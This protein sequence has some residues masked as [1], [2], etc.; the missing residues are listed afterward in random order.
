MDNSVAI[1]GIGDIELE[2]GKVKDGLS[3]LQIQALSAK[4]A[5]NDAGIKK[6]EVD[7]MF[8]SGMWHKAGYGTAPSALV[9]E[10][11]GIQPR[12]TDSTN[13]GGASF[14]AHIGHAAAAIKD[15]KCE[16]ALIVY[17]STQRSDKSR[18]N[19]IPPILTAQYESPFGLPF[20]I[21]SYGMAAN[22][23]M[24]QYGVKQEDLAEVAVSARKWGQLNP[25]ATKRENLS[26]KDVLDSPI[27]SH[28]LHKLDCCLVT[29]GA[30]AIVLVSSEKAKECR[31]KPIWVLGHGE[32][33][34]HWS[35]QPMPDLTVSSAKESAR[36]AFEMSGISRKEID[37]VQVYDSFTI[38]VLI[39]L[40]SLG[41]CKPGEAPDFIKTKGI[42][43]DGNFPI[44]TSGGGLAHCHPGMYGIFLL[45]EAVRQLREEADGRQ[46]QNAKTALVNGTGGVLSSTSVC[47]LGRD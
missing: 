8:V 4:R 9:S 33:H 7:G 1:A 41:F 21:G 47:I 36:D 12:Y 46:V 37:V 14:E 25:S 40:E 11:L 34:S 22:R 24:H 18:N 31:K 10:Y 3:V 44:N 23:Y 29:D 26:V 15:G 30:G 39:T 19:G 5:L 20:P 42:A 13:I 27:I 45:I 6:N 17:G 38:T 2:N 16:V 32:S 35:I 28:P 43:P